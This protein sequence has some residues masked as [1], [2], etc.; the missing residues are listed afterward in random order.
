MRD[1]RMNAWT[2]GREGGNSGLDGE[3]KFPKNYYNLVEWTFLVFWRQ[4][5]KND[6]S[7]R[8]IGLIS[9]WLNNLQWRW[10]LLKTGWAKPLLRTTV[11]A[12]I[13]DHSWLERQETLFGRTLVNF[14]EKLSENTVIFDDFL[15]KWT[16][17]LGL[18]VPKF[19]RTPS[20]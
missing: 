19:N 2:H 14:G 18:K 8:G 3:I 17:V 5:P 13:E 6:D 20:F 11:S 10:K 16:I 9:Y 4:V 15:L 1:G 7:N 12:Q